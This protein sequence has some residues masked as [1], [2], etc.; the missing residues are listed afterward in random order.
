MILRDS[1]NFLE[2]WGKNYKVHGHRIMMQKLQICPLGAERNG[3][4]H[5]RSVTAVYKT[6]LQVNIQGV[7]E[8]MMVEEQTSFLKN[9]QS[10]GANC[11]T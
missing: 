5:E 10:F 3:W 6:S 9:P 4:H 8:D 2:Y 11:M 7:Q 1:V